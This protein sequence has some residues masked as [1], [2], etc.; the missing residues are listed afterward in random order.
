MNTLE[1]KVIIY[2]DVCPLCNAYTGCFVKLGWLNNR[3]GFAQ[4]G[5][6][7]MAHIDLDRARHEI[8]LYD[9]ESKATLYG[10]DAL[11]LILGT[12][13]PVFK[14]LFRSRSFRAIVK[15]LYQI[16]TYNRRIIAGSRAPEQG[17]D[18]APDRNPFYRW[19]YIVLATGT[20]GAWYAS[21]W[22]AN[23]QGWYLILALVQFAFLAFGLF[24]NRDRLSLLGHWATI[25]LILALVGCFLPVQPWSLLMLLPL[26]LWCWYARRDLALS[27]PRF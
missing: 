26:A 16:I 20:A 6:E 4:A 10:L 25:S 13:M 2:D 17:F 27:I 7:L 22:P 14:P 9:T 11:F 12:K 21:N 3:T 23:D 19:V 8:P 24:R 1:H 5:P 18:C 15:Q